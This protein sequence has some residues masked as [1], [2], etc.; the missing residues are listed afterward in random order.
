VPNALNDLHE[1]LSYAVEGEYHI[2]ELDVRV[3][4]AWAHLREGN[5]SQ[6]AAEAE[7]AK[8]ESVRMGYYWGEIDANELL[9]SCQKSTD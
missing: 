5:L 4:M 6:A 9:R 3:G 7:R 1:A 2:Y 8:S